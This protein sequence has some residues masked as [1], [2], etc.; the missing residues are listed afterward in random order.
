MFC[1]WIIY[2]DLLPKNDDEEEENHEEEGEEH[3]E[4]IYQKL[5]LFV[6]KVSIFVDE[7]EVIHTIE[8]EEEFDFKKFIMR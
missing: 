2:L 5:F 6:S 3:D 7:E 8:R 4:G 1:F